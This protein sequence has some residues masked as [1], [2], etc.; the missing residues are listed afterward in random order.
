MINLDL[1][2]P[3]RANKPPN[4]NIGEAKWLNPEMEKIFG[5]G[6]SWPKINKSYEVVRNDGLA[7]S[8]NNVLKELIKQL[9]RC[10]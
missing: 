10:S 7:H 1:P 4:Q 2:E 6:E 5:S 3:S 9:I 8:R